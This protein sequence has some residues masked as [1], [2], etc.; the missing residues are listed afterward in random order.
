MMKDVA[1]KNGFELMELQR[2]NDIYS[3]I[4]GF[5]VEQRLI[6]DSNNTS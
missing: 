1:V 2:F 6:E 4:R 3:S 5:S